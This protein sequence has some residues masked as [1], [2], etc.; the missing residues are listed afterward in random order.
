[1]KFFPMKRLEWASLIES[2]KFEHKRKAT[3]H[4]FQPRREDN[5]PGGEDKVISR[6]IGRFS[7]GNLINAS[8]R[9]YNMASRRGYPPASRQMYDYYKSK[10]LIYP[11][12]PPLVSVLIC[13]RACT[14]VLYYI[15]NTYICVGVNFVKSS[16]RTLWIFR[17]S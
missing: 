10:E 11:P 13:V 6:R 17:L 5:G 4:I 2:L 16:S 3:L 9:K 7:G 14:Y 1:M 8:T 15:C 12:F